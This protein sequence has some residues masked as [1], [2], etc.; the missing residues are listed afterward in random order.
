[1]QI[2]EKK[3]FFLVRKAVVRTVFEKNTKIQFLH[4]FYFQEKIYNKKFQNFVRLVFKHIY[5][6]YLLFTKNF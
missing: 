1:M 4:F 2:Y 3:R 6:T 5:L